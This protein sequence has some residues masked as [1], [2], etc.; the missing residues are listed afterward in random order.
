MRAVIIIVIYLQVMLNQKSYKLISEYSQFC[1]LPFA[2]KL[3][4]VLPSLTIP[5]EQII[6]ENQS[7]NVLKL[8]NTTIF[9]MIFFLLCILEVNKGPETRKNTECAYPCSDTFSPDTLLMPPCLCVCLYRDN[10]TIL[11]AELG[12]SRQ[13][14]AASNTM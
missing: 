2:P 6:E 5:E 8:Q 7:I 1:I 10:V 14:R 11:R 3:F 13:V 4:Y 12:E 9:R